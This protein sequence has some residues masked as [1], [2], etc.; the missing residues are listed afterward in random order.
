MLVFLSFLHHCVG[1]DLSYP[2]SKSLGVANSGNPLS[3][4]QQQIFPSF[5]LL[6]NFIPND[7]TKTLLLVLTL[8]GHAVT[9]WC[10]FELG[11][12]SEIDATRCHAGPPARASG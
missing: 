11:R 4:T 9:S 7:P 5:G 8:F 2:D 12:A 6:I 1:D 10:D 3:Y